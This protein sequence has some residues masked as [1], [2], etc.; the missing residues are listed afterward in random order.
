MRLTLY[1]RLLTEADAG[2]TEFMDEVFQ[3]ETRFPGGEWKAASEP[4]TDVVSDTLTMR[5]LDF[6]LIQFRFVVFI[7]LYSYT[8]L[9][10]KE[11]IKNVAVVQNGEKSRNPGEFDCPPGWV[12]EDEWTV[13][14]NRAVDDQGAHIVPYWRKSLIV[15]RC[16]VL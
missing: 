8:V 3:N 11:R 5:R 10:G 15:C 12:W 14:D 16:I 7:L 1:F 9:N 13:D 2:H 4:F 6:N